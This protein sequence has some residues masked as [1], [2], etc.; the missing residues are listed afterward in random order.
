MLYPQK[1]Y[2]SHVQHQII[3]T[4]S[5]NHGIKN[6]G[7]LETFLHQKLILALQGSHQE[8]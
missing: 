1:Q 2:A 8:K 4:S 6:R 3:G 5:D 7:A